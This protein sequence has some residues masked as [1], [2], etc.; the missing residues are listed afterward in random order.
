MSLLRNLVL[1][2]SIQPWANFYIY[3][4]AVDIPLFFLYRD[5][6]VTRMFSNIFT[7]LR[8]KG[9]IDAQWVLHSSATKMIYKL[10]SIVL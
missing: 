10:Y 6:P 9:P 7:W 5:S 2:V 3:H 4:P 8:N 1:Y